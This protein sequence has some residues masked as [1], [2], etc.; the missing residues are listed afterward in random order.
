[1]KIFGKSQKRFGSWVLNNTLFLIIPSSTLV[2]QI[3]PKRI[4]QKHL[5]FHKINKV[6]VNITFNQNKFKSIY[7]QA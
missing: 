4:I 2:A 5:I 1:M 3:F 6:E 7:T